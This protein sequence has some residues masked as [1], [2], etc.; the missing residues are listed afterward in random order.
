MRDLEVGLMSPSKSKIVLRPSSKRKEIEETRHLPRNFF[1]FVR[2]LS[3]VR[4]DAKSCVKG[5]GAQPPTSMN[6]N[7]KSKNSRRLDVP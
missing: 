7:E 2:L 6:L 5:A 3:G 4:L 1:L